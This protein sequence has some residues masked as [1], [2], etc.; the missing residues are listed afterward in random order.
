MTGGPGVGKTALLREL[1][2]RGVS[3]VPEAAR[4]IIQ[5]Q[6]SSGGDAV[7]WMNTK[8]YASLMLERSI[9]DYLDHARTER[10]TFF[11]RGIL[12]TIGY[13]RLIGLHLPE[14]IYRRA[15]GCRCNAKVFFAS[16]WLEIYATDSERKQT[17]EEA[18]AVDRLLR[19]VYAEH[20]YE[21]VD[22]PQTTVEKRADFVLP[23]LES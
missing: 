12:D 4:Q 3:C 22:I 23:F 14:E 5:E 6:V 20:G 16:P 17:F 21:I 15:I 11:D 8:R 10:V 18:V 1:E 7:P 9:Q 19:E 13:M 2:R